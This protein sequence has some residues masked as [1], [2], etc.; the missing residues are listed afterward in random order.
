MV[1][2]LEVLTLPLQHSGDI[3]VANTTYAIVTAA[4]PEARAQE[5]QEDTASSYGMSRAALQL[6]AEAL[7]RTGPLVSHWCIIYAGRDGK[8]K[9]GNREM[10]STG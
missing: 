10:L 1:F 9:L 6:C 2:N 4:V 5:A 3:L 8:S 7:A